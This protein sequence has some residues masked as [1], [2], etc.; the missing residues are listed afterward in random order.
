M[1]TDPSLLC[2]AARPDPGTAFGAG[3]ARRGFAGLSQSLAGAGESAGCRAGCGGCRS[4]EFFLI[5][6]NR[7]QPMPDPEPLQRRQFA[8]DNYAGIAPEAWEAMRQANS[9]HAPAYGDD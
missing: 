2:P 4:G 1:G 7:N 3:R 8:S 6:A 5:I 9:G